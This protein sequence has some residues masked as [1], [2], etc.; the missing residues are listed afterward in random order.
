MTPA[1]SPAGGPEEITVQRLALSVAG[2]DEPAARRL[3]GL[4]ADGL[5]TSLPGA[6]GLSSIEGLRVE[7]D[8]A[9]LAAPTPELVAGRVVEAIA[10]ALA[11][12]A[13]AD[14]AATGAGKEPTR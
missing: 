10:R 9:D 2:L 11:S 8:A 13:A 4:V 1:L 6:S 5:A 7:I 14:A 12:R 3:A